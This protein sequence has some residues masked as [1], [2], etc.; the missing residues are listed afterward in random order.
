MQRFSKFCS[1]SSNAELRKL[2][3]HRQHLTTAKPVP[4]W[5]K[6]LA[7][8]LVA[9]SSKIDYNHIVLV[10]QIKIC[11]HLSASLTNHLYKLLILFVPVI[12]PVIMFELL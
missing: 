7:T 1:V 4:P 3:K 12:L 11:Q 9:R 6:I 5:H 2:Y 10:G 8:P